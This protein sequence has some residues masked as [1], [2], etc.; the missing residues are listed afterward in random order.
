[1][2]LRM[3]ASPTP[4]PAVEIAQTPTPTAPVIPVESTTSADASD[5]A[6]ASPSASTK[7]STATG[8]A[9]S[10]A[11]AAQKVLVVNATD[12]AGYAGQI[13]TKLATGGFKA[14][15]AGN[16]KGTYTTEGDFIFQKAADETAIA[17]Y[18]KASGL[19][20]TTVED[21]DDEDPQ[22]TY[23]VVIILNQ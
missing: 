13:R 8:S 3:S 9:P 10:A 6:S 21:A 5:S 15:T 12:K 4:T 11:V 7:P 18:E 2:V 23:D 1:M 17:A 20:L 22:G 16:A 14:V 19:T